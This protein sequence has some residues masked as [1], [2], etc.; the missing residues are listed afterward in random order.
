[1]NRLDLQE[2]LPDELIPDNDKHF[3]LLTIAGG[4]F[5]VV[6]YSYKDV[7]EYVN[8]VF[9]GDSISKIDI[10]RI[11][12]DANIVL[13]ASRDFSSDSNFAL[14]T[15]LFTISVDIPSTEKRIK[16]VTDDVIFIL[17]NILSEDDVVNI[18]LY[19]DHAVIV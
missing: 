14:N 10:T 17:D 4:E 11:D 5:I 15:R 16:I 7:W 6:A 13:N 9:H 8:S 18:S 12:Y 2:I 3:F 1:M 19:T